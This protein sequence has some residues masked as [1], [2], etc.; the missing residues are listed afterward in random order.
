MHS[1]DRLYHISD[2]VF[3][4]SAK[5]FQSKQLSNKNIAPKSLAHLINKKICLKKE[6][7]FLVM[8]DLRRGG[9]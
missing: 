2:C 9:Q 4:A 3:P 8:F 7:E 6:G 5:V 1:L